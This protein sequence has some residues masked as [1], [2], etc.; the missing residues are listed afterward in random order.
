MVRPCTIVLK[1][2]HAMSIERLGCCVRNNAHETVHTL[3]LSFF[4]IQNRFTMLPWNDEHGAALKLSLIDLRYCVLV[5]GNDRALSC[6]RK[7]VA[8]A[9]GSVRWKLESH[10]RPMQKE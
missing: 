5:L 4:D 6:T 3:N 9:A 10:W 7:I 8:E 1:D 2:A